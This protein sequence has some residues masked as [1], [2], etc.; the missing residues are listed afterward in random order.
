MRQLKITNK[1]TNRESLS[2]DKYLNDISKI[3]LVTADQEAQLA[4]KI[5]EGDQEAV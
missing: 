5:R 4:R 2:L 3:E 1:I